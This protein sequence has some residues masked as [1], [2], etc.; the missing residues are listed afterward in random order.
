MLYHARTK[1]WYNVKYDEEDDILSLN[2]KE[3][4]DNGDLVV[5]NL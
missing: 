3:D 1:H 2:L 5:V 4:Y